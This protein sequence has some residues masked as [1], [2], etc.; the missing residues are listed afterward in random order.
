MDQDQRLN[1]GYNAALQRADTESSIIWGTFNALV[2]ANSIVIG[3][4][5]AMSSSHSVSAFQAFAVSLFGLAVCLAWFL[6]LNRQFAYYAYWFAW[7]RTLERA[8]LAPEVQIIALGQL[9]ARGEAVRLS[10][11]E[12]PMQM[13]L[14]ARGFRIETLAKCV[15]GLFAVAYIL[16]LCFS[17]KPL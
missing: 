14:L 2:T 3:L 10:D 8:L 5:V 16:L 1:V 13:G 7:A 9:Y 12:A 4:Y 17:V 6:M 11:Q 15:I